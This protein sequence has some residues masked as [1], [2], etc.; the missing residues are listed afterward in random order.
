M[1]VRGYWFG[2]C[3]AASVVTVLKLTEPYRP[4][5]YKFC[6]T[7]M[8]LIITFVICTLNRVSKRRELASAKLSSMPVRRLMNVLKRPVLHT[9]TMGVASSVTKESRGPASLLNSSLRTCQEEGVRSWSTTRN[10]GTYLSK[11]TVLDIVHCAW[12]IL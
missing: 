12:P 9:L 11:Y 2:T 10:H 5:N 7:V 4:G 1:F 3:A 8:R 6:I